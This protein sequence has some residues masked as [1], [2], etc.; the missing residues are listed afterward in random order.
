MKTMLITGG[1]VFVSQF[2]AR[3]FSD[4]YRVYVLNRNTRPQCT[5]VT[6]LEGDRHQLNGRLRER[7]FDAVLDI[8]AYDAEDVND[9]LDGLGG[10]GSYLLISSSA[11]YP[12]WGRQP[13][14][15]EAAVGPN[16]IWGKYG[17]DKIAAENAL[18]NRVENAYILRPP[19]LYGPGNNVY[20]EA[21]VF[22]CALQNRR[23]C[24][25]G[26]GEMKLQF[27]HVEDLC[28]F[29]ERLLQEKPAQRIFNVGNRQAVSVRE[30]V[31]L[32]YQAA[33]KR[34]ECLSV[35]A[36]LEQRNYFPFYRYDYYLDV[37]KQHALMPETKT[38]EFGLQEAFS[39]YLAHSAEVRKKP[40]IAYIDENLKEYGQ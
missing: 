1:T 32:C 19:Y 26:N 2:A 17:T 37:E 8:T 15:E 33:G 5:G 25:P 20:R 7:Y 11:V 29:I 40:L 9:L 30:W 3:Y 31:E 39:W 27:F 22:D 34:P 13:F 12:E 14:T 16:R 23:F 4:R 18:L 36:D 21:F 24:L 28:R 6:L 35:N 10:F 38:L